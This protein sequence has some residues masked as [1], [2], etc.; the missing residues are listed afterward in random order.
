MQ[1]HQIGICWKL[2]GAESEL[3]IKLIIIETIDEDW[4]EGERGQQISN[5]FIELSSVTINTLPFES[6]CLCV[7]LCVCDGI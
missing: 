6:K 2:Y 1:I 5:W 4:S 3:Q 7:C